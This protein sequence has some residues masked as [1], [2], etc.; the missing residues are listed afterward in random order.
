VPVTSNLERELRQL[1]WPY[2]KLVP[3]TP[4]LEQRILNQRRAPRPQRQRSTWARDLGLSAILLLVVMGVAI[5]IRDARTVHPGAAVHNQPGPVREASPAAAPSF[6]AQDLFPMGVTNPALITPFDLQS[7][8]VG[9]TITLVGAYADTS[10]IVAIFRM[11]PPNWQPDAVTI[12]DD[13]GLINASSGGWPGIAGDY[14]FTLNG[15]PHVDSTQTAHLVIHI[16]YVNAAQQFDYGNWN[17]SIQLKVHS[18]VPLPVPTQFK[19]GAWTVRVEAF[20]QTPSVIHFQA[21]IDG[22][23]LFTAVN[24]VS[25]LDPTGKKIGSGCEAVIRGP[26]Q[27]LA[28]GP[29]TSARIKCDFPVPTSPGTYEIRI[30]GGGGAYSLPFGITATRQ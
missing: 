21:A 5:G 25:L 27:S 24:A 4:T 8:D 18:P 19:V 23:D 26:K 9:Q 28:A 30:A 11:Q 17:F 15:G 29:P 16:H 3:S 2:D 10:R 6:P 13:L 14:V 20:E 22:T 7:S 12:D 1:R